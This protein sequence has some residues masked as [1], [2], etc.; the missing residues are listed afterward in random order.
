[1]RPKERVLLLNDY[2]QTLDSKLNALPM[3]I[4]HNRHS[5][6]SYSQGN[7]HKHNK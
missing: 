4:Q 5:A 7:N 6:Y 3:S 2:F 1:M